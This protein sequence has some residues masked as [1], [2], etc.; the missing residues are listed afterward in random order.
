MPTVNKHKEHRDKCVRSPFTNLTALV[1]RPVTSEE[2]RE[3]PEAQVA[4]KKKWVG[5]RAK[6]AWRIQVV[7]EWE[8]GVC[9]AARQFT[10]IVHVGRVFGF[11][12][13][14]GA[15]LPKGHN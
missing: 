7:R 6:P 5:L 9:A 14:K 8:G 4:G 2:M 13:E 15:Q 11:C 10:R 3:A 12:V 1:A